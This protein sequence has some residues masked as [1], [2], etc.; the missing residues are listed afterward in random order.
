MNVH[1]TEI[2]LSDLRAIEAYVS[3]H[4]EWSCEWTT[5]EVG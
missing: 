1:W 4:S 5:P 2:A 3:R